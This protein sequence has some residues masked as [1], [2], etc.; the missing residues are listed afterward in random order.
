MKIYKK[1]VPV[2]L[3]LLVMII[4]CSCSKK[5]PEFVDYMTNLSITPDFSGSRTIKLTYPSSVIDPKSELAESF[6]AVIRKNCPSSMTYTSQ[7]ADDKLIYTFTLS[8]SSISDYRSKLTELLGNEPSVIFSNSNTVLAK[9]WRIDEDFQSSQ[10]MKW[11]NNS[12]KNDGVEIPEHKIQELDT[13]VAFNGESITSDPVISINKRSGSPIEKISI[14]TLNKTTATESLY[15]RTI[16]FDITQKTFDSLGDKVKQYFS[17]VTEESAYTEWNLEK[18][19]YFYTVKFKNITLKQL[20]G[21]TN[22]LL[23]TVYGDITYIDKTVGSTALAYQ[24]SYCE[25][26]DFSGYVGPDNSDVPVEYTYS[27]SNNSKLDECRIYSDMK[28]ESAANLLETN[29]PGKIVALYNQSPSITLMI[30]DGKQYVPE[31]IDISVTPLDN[32]NISKSIAFIYDISK[33]GYEATDYT[34]SY[35][36]RLGII[37]QKTVDG[38]NSVCTVNFSGSDSEIN[39]K[40]T[41]IFGDA[42]IIISKSEIPFMTL[43]TKKIIDDTVDLSSLLVGENIDTPVNYIVQPADGELAESLTLQYIDSED[44]VECEPDKNGRYSFTISNTEAKLSFVVS[45]PNIADI[46]I[47]CIIG[48]IL[49]LTAV[50]IM[51]YMRSR[52][53]NT[54]ELPASESRPVLNE[55]KKRTSAIIRRKKPEEKGETEE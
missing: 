16:T 19:H 30:N 52:V 29:N 44:K 7:K 17:S 4:L 13:K 12:A 39:V 55:G 9:G 43:R 10:L 1:A 34:A 8:F 33:N 40:L 18:E 6:E 50:G 47:F 42:N 5:E 49:V 14:T 36:E 15:D 20:E 28:W 11:I 53:K 21:Y 3:A 41:D 38:G 27:L 45:A 54:P 2:I 48:M 22:R 46:I 31:S 51:L 23:S 26:L 32:N 35:F 25:S 24:N 37:A